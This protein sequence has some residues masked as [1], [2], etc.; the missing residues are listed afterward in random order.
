M[1][2]PTPALDTIDRV[3]PIL[4]I[5]SIGLGL[6]LAAVWPGGADALGPVVSIGVFILIYAVMLGVDPRGAAA[7]LTNQRF[8]AI[9]VVLNFVVNPAIA[10]G[11]G[12]VFLGGDP[13]LFA[14]FVLFLVTPCIGW[15]LIF[16]E[17]ADGDTD[18]G[19]SLLVINIGLQVLLLP[20]YL[21]LLVGRAVTIDGATIAGSV[22]L[23]LVAPS[24][25]A[26]ATR[27]LADRTGRQID[28]VRGHPGFGWAK[29]ATLM[30]IVVAIFASQAD[31]I[32]ANKDAVAR[33][34]PPTIA[35]FAM[36]FLI[37]VTVGRVAALPPAHT[38]LLVFTTS[39][40]NSEASLAIAATAF[41]SPLVTVPVAIGPAIEL[42]ILVVMVR[43]LRRFERAE[44]RTPPI[45]PGLPQTGG[46][47]R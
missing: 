20:V 21:W 38:V 42:P 13:N 39:A 29:T 4:L 11:L 46:I 40:R 31:V 8:V 10:W 30:V 41:A 26:I 32:L 35:F 34:V 2:E 6:G 23:Y 44:R 18:L 1:T 15:Y 19:V 3:Q 17:L 36:T 22:G 27:W 7:A 16:T 25:L 9:T 47:A 37:A 28:D 5:A 45:G 33:L 24:V 14:G 43:L 12:T